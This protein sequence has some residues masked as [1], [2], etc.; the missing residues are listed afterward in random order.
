VKYVFGNAQHIGARAQQQDSFCFSSPDDSSFLGHAGMLAVLADGMG[1]LSHGDAA[2]RTAATAFLAAY[3]QKNEHETIPDALERS[4]RDANAAV[5]ALAQEHHAD[6]QLGTTLVAA[7]LR[8]NQL[9][10][11]SVGDSGLFLRRGDDLAQLNTAH[12]YANDLDARAASGEIAREA[13]LKDPQREALTSHLG[14]A[15]IPQVDQS[16]RPLTLEPGDVVLLASD[17]LFKTLPRQEMLAAM[18]GSL[19]EQCDILVERVVA[20]GIGH[21]DNTTVMALAA[22]DDNWT[23]PAP[24]SSPLPATESVP[25]GRSRKWVVAAVGIILAGLAGAGFWMHNQRSEPEA[26]PPVTGEL[27][28]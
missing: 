25:G 26:P 14:L 28:P 8:E 7:V 5:Y 15:Q 17:G 27:G 16:R 9:H 13:A 12:V 10:W 4:L 21:Q 19:Q 23:A 2:G 24:D 22:V 20:K 11:V 6:G 3:R 18:S 1:G